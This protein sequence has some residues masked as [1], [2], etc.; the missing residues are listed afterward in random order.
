[1]GITAQQRLLVRCL[2]RMPVVTAGRL[3]EVMHV[4]PGTVSAALR[5]LELKGIV[6]RTRPPD[7][8]RR[9]LVTLTARGRALDRPADGTV[10]QAVETLLT[11]LPRAHVRATRRALTE[12]TVLMDQ[13]RAPAA[14]RTRSSQR[15][16]E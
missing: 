12:L 9:V 5:R 7:D 2:G 4:D 13:A 14:R 15:Q 16:R 8:R 1:M 6:R 3:A 10:E 11:L